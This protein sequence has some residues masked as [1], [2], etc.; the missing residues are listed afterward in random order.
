MKM[1]HVP[2]VMNRRSSFNMIPPKP[3]S[4]IESA[5]NLVNGVPDFNKFTITAQLA[6]KLSEAI[7]ILQDIESQANAQFKAGDSHAT[8]NWQTLEALGFK[9]PKIRKFRHKGGFRDTTD[10]IIPGWIV[11]RDGS[12]L[13]SDHYTLER[14]LVLVKSGNWIELP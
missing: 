5:T 12:R 2:I 4:F 11:D 9:F 1:H 3:K 10:Y 6:N 13:W 7:D 14:C 8:F